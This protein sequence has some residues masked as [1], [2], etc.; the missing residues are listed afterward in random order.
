[1]TDGLQLRIQSRY[2]KRYWLDVVVSNRTTLATLDRFLRRTWLEC[3]GHMS[4]FS[5]SG[6]PAQ[7]LSSRLTVPEAFTRGKVIDYVYD[8]G[9]TTQLVIRLKK[10]VAPPEESITLLAR[11]EPPSYPCDECGLPAVS[12]CI[13]CSIEE[14]GLLCQKH[15]EDHLCGEEALLPVVNSPR[16]GVCGYCG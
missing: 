15:G 7:E 8:F 14:G 6:R 5:T 10:V 1:M 11:N 2:D 9:S 12:I 16:M 3:C 4:A 13:G